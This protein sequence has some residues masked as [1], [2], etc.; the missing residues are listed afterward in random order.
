MPRR[1]ARSKRQIVAALRAAARKLGHTP[2]ANELKRLAGI[3]INQVRGRFRAYRVALHAAGL[4]PDQSG[5]RVE[6]AA[7]LEDWARIVR[8]VGAV[9]VRREY[10]KA[11]TYSSECF[12][13]RFRGWMKVPAAFSTAVAAGSLAGDWADVLEK[14]HHGPIPTKGGCKGLAKKREAARLAR[15][16]AQIGCRTQCPSDGSAGSPCRDHGV[17]PA[18]SRNRQPANSSATLARHEMRDGHHACGFHR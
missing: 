14:I 18:A 3:S 4:K 7:L 6:T 2:T 10:E 5:L 16:A 17:A 1:K 12:D 13:K 9:P 8:K 11:G 15:E